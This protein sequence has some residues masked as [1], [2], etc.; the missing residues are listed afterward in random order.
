MGGILFKNLDSILGMAVA[1][2]DRF[3][4]ISKS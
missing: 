1:I 4:G 2:N 3:L